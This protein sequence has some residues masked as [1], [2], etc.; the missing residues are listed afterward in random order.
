[1]TQLRRLLI[2]GLAFLIVGCG[3]EQPELVSAE[4]GTFTGVGTNDVTFTPVDQLS[5]KSEA[6]YGWKVNTR[7][8]EGTVTVKDEVETPIPAQW[9]FPTNAK[10]QVSADKKT[11]SAT[12][13]FPV[14]GTS[15]LF[16]NW[17]LSPSDPVGTYRTRL[18]VN[19]QLIKEVSFEVGE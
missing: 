3:R 9:E 17:S 11:V 10:V 14:K 4:F 7:P 1:M 8:F 19:N 12:Q 5:K 6:I 13:S 16:H 2:L 15:F 18:Y